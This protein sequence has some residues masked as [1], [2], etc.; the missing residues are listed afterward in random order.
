[1]GSVID[2]TMPASIPSNFG[3]LRVHDEQLVRFGLLAEKYFA[4][5]PNTYFLKLRQFG[6]VLAQLVASRA[7]LY[8]VTEEPQSELLRRLQDASAPHPR[9]ECRRPTRGISDGKKH[10]NLLG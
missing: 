10:S 5:D 6:E 4:D 8:T 3:F 1:L 9:L 7:G 2:K